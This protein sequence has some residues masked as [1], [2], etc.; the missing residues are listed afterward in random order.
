MYQQD[1]EE[2]KQGC[3]QVVQLRNLNVQCHLKVHTHRGLFSEVWAAKHNQLVLT[4]EDWEEDTLPK[5][6]FHFEVQGRSL[7]QGSI[8]FQVPRTQYF[9]S[10]K[11]PINGFEKSYDLILPPNPPRSGQCLCSSETNSQQL[12][13][14]STDVSFVSPGGTCGSVQYNMANEFVGSPAFQFISKSETLAVPKISCT[15]ITA[16]NNIFADKEVRGRNVIADKGII[17]NVIQ[18]NDI[19]TLN[20]VAS[21]SNLGNSIIDSAVIQRDLKIGCGFYTATSK[22]VF[23]FTPETI[24]KIDSRV[25][26][27]GGYVNMQVDAETNFLN[28]NVSNLE[29]PDQS[30]IYSVTAT[31]ANS[32][33]CG[34]VLI[35]YDPNNASEF[36]LKL[37][38]SD[39]LGV[40]DK[41]GICWNR[42]F[43]TS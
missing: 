41:I 30:L 37:H 25:G 36:T 15:S 17:S 10:L 3:V 42:M 35:D 20:I 32:P 43:W 31:I 1:W 6:K 12:T 21:D 16:S 5:D 29:S 38:M 22:A 23:T 19:Q 7:F 40:N 28:V 33:K 26:I 8:C 13:W 4:D 39:K 24:R 27:H 11:M 9:M 14:K 34:S 2:S 18:A